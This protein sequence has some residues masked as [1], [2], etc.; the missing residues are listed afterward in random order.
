MLRAALVVLA[1]IASSVQ[2]AAAQTS[3]AELAAR[4]LKDARLL[5][6]DPAELPARNIVPPSRQTSRVQYFGYRLILGGLYEPT[7][8]EDETWIDVGCQSLDPRV[9]WDRNDHGS[10]SLVR[11]HAIVYELD[12][13][14]SLNTDTA[15]STVDT[16]ALDEG[17][18]DVSRGIDTTFIEIPRTFEAAVVSLFSVASRGQRAE[19]VENVERTLAP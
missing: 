17:V 19:V 2:P 16:S 3:N 14:G 12:R 9:S 10:S 1:V 5:D 8:F 6:V 18:C 13:D 15:I 7:I 11:V 4:Q